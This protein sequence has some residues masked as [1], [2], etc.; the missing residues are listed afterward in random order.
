MFSVF[1]AGQRVSGRCDQVAAYA[2]VAAQGSHDP[3]LTPGSK[4]WRGYAALP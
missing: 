3:G 2:A 4:C 1:W